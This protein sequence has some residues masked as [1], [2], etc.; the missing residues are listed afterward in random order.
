MVEGHGEG[1]SLTHGSLKPESKRPGSSY[2]N[3]LLGHTPSDLPLPPGPISQQH[4][5]L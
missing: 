5:Q 3:T 2:K 1:Q 4:I